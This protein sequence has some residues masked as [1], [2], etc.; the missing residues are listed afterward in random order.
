MSDATPEGRP[1]SAWFLMALI[2][3]LIGGIVT[4]SVAVWWLSRVSGHCGVVR[5]YEQAAAVIL[6]GGWLAGTASRIHRP[7]KKLHSARRRLRHRNHGK[8]RRG[9]RLRLG[10]T[11]AKGGGLFT[12][13]HAAT[14]RAPF[15]G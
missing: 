5:F 4:L 6:V 7:Q 1:R 9:G 8:H 15:G 2:A 10:G 14:S 3:A 12:Q 11:C 13:G